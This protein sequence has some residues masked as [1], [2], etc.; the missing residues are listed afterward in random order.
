M[1]HSL[2]LMGFLWLIPHTL[3]ENLAQRDLK[4]DV[5]KQVGRLASLLSCY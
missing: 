4:S 3:A 5:E 2:M 1:E